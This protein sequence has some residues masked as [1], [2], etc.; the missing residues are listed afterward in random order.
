MNSSAWNGE[1]N[2]KKSRSHIR[3]NT[4][5]DKI[6]LVNRFKASNPVE[7]MCTALHLNWS[8][9]YKDSKHNPTKAQVSNDE[10]D[11]KILKVYYE[12]KK[13]S[14]A[15]KIFKAIRNE[16]EAASL[17]RSQRREGGSRD[18]ICH[19]KE[20]R[21]CKGWEKCRAEGEHH[22]SRFYRHFNQ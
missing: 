10:L 18:K 7:T 20:I 3:Q 19:C 12:T 16:G 8:S 14:G 2:P 1:W 13:R 9:Y 11:S 15:P 21:A 4:V 22:E 6:A 17:K 5:K